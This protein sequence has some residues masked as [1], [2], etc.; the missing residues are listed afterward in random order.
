MALKLDV[1][2]GEFLEE[3]SYPDYSSPPTG[4]IHPRIQTEL[5]F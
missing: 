1:S 4:P 2:A 3:K 5:N